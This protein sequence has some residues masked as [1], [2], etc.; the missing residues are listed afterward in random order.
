MK[1]KV[2]RGVILIFSG[3]ILLFSL[4]LCASETEESALEPENTPQKIL[5]LAN[6]TTKFRNEAPNQSIK[7]GEDALLLL[8]TNE[9]KKIEVQV[10]NDLCWSY[11]NIGQFQKATECG[12]RSI[13]TAG[14][15][16]DRKGLAIAHKNMGVLR[17][18]MNKV[19]ESLEHFG[20]AL[21]SFRQIQLR[22]EIGNTLNNMGLV[23][24]SISDYDK[25]LEYYLE[26]LDIYRELD[27]KEGMGLVYNNVG[28][29][30]LRL[31]RYSEALAYYEKAL[32][33]AREL[34]QQWSISDALTNIGVVYYYDKKYDLSLDY[35][36]QALE[37]S[38]NVRN[39]FG[40]ANILNNI[41]EVYIK[42][43]D[44]Q[45]AMTYCRESF[46]LYREIGARYGMA[47]TLNNF[48]ILDRRT[49]KPWD[50]IRHVNRAKILAKEIKAK[51]LIRNAHRILSNVYDDLKDYK[52]ALE[53]HR[54]YKK[55]NDEMYNEA[56][57]RK[58][59]E[60]RIKYK[61]E[62]KDKELEILKR[63]EDI[64]EL[65]LKK[66]RSLQN[67][68]M[69][70]SFLVV[71]VA[72]VLYNRYKVKVRGTLELQKEIQEHKRTHKKLQESEEKFRTLAEKSLVGIYIIQDNIFKYLNPQF[73]RLLEY[74]PGDLVDHR[75]LPDVVVKSD[76]QAI[77]ESLKKRLEGKAE[78]AHH[79]FRAVK[80]S[81]E[82]IHLESFDSITLYNSRPAILGTVIDM[83]DHKR[84]E[85]ELLKRRKLESTSILAAGIAHDF[86]NLLIS[87][88]GSLNLLKL[89]FKRR[90]KDEETLEAFESLETSSS[91]AMDLAQKLITF[92]SGGW[93]QREKLELD[94]L[95]QTAIEYIPELK[96]RGY[97][98]RL[99]KDLPALHVDERQFRQVLQNLLLNAVEADPELQVISISAERYKPENPTSLADLNEPL[100]PR[101]YIKI[102]IRDRGMGIPA[103]QL[104]RIFDPYFSTK[105]SYDQQGLGLG[106]SICYAIVKKH[107]GHIAI[108][109]EQDE[110]TVVFLYL[111]AY[112]ESMETD[113]FYFTKGELPSTM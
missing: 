3:L 56:D 10:L 64:Q 59:A 50:A 73:C 28:S 89:K 35:Y 91:Q 21:K 23:Y 96:E 65:E 85:N 79:E 61:T 8:K 94:F 101:E 107:D 48:G 74:Q 77:E 13:E 99:P 105:N 110:G 18:Q 67:S 82:I 76:Q 104:E 49:G 106:L 2:Y 58:I 92:C 111:P 19:N 84:A 26:A 34:K 5:R 70:I 113:A 11:R 100:P 90:K 46:S 55:V 78:F 12:N 1:R 41:A 112:D 69:F 52:T 33:I 57:T 32:E 71:I 31:T 108:E 87:I 81:G 24:E 17:S 4:Y 7:Y 29:V 39:K 75:S 109:S 93:M 80:K 63:D 30:Y 40:T 27:D 15:N 22:V 68:L 9:N 83:T 37:L 43:E 16:N 25:T 38:R 54:Q 95:L 60:M 72:V 88:M 20:E 6:L 102:S 86:N 66:Q 51:D 103:D 14:E 98:I 36:R 47:N 44:F 62:K 42:L 53:H 97:E 45:Q